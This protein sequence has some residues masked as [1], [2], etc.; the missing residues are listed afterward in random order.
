MRTDKWGKDTSWLVRDD[1]GR[2]IVESM[3]EYGR[4]EMD[5]V[6][7]CLED[8]AVSEFVFRDTVGDGVVSSRSGG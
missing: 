8:G 4:N 5:S 6:E 3:K 1:R 7:M 2:T